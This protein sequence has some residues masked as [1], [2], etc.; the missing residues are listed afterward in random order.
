MSKVLVAVQQLGGIADRPGLMCP[1]ALSHWM[2]DYNKENR[3][4]YTKPQHL[5]IIEMMN[6]VVDCKVDDKYK[7]KRVSKL[8]NKLIN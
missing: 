5:K 1:S 4:T 8:V 3:K 7:D 2:L 6:S